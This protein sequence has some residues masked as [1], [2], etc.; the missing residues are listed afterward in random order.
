MAQKDDPEALGQATISTPEMRPPEVVDEGRK[1]RLA[2]LTQKG[3]PK[4][5]TRR[6]TNLSSRERKEIMVQLAENIPHAA[7]AA[8]FGISDSTVA[9][10]RNEFSQIFKSLGK[11]EPYRKVKADLFDATELELLKS[12]NDSDKLERASL[13]QVAYSLQV[14]HNAGRLE[15]NLST[16][17]VNVNTYLRF[18][19]TEK[20][21][22]NE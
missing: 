17:N 7:I 14:V 22:G 2:N 11:V 21:E 10:I 6:A 3:R 5:V 1:K 20:V 12:L 4:G 15:K 16:A 8:Q 9:S 18:E 13:N 19:L